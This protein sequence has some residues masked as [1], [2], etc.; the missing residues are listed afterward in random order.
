[1][2]PRPTGRLAAVL[3]L[4]LTGAGLAGCGLK[5]A[6]FPAPESELGNG[7]GL[8]SGPSGEFTIYRQ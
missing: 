2:S 4:L 6:P 5:P 8:L 7:P 3:F 1:L